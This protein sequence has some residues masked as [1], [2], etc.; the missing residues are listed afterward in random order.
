MPERLTDQTELTTAPENDDIVYVVDVSDTTDNPAG[1]SKQQTFANFTKGIRGFGALLPGTLSPSGSPATL[2]FKTTSNP[3]TDDYTAIQ[4]HDIVIRADAARCV[5][6]YVLND[7]TTFP[8]DFD[9]PT[10]FAK[11]IDNGPAL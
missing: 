9:D 2:L 1:S 5:I 11:Y 7:F 3:A 6:G 10:K 4:Q 8:D